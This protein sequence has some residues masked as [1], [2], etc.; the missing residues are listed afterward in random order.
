[1]SEIN[2]SYDDFS[3]KNSVTQS[4]DDVSLSNDNN[5]NSINSKDDDSR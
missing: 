4:S 5:F 3:Q 1:M 2:S